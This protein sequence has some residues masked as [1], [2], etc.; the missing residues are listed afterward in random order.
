VALRGASA[1][2]LARSFQPAPCTL[3]VRLPDMSGWTVLEPPEAPIGHAS[4][5]VPR[6]SSGLEAISLTG[7]G[8]K[9]VDRLLPRLTWTGYDA[10]TRIGFQVV[11]NGPAAHVRSPH[12]QKSNRGRLEAPRKR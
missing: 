6:H 5:S 4:Y 7:G 8:I 9:R 3:D 1:I 11:E 10:W 12:I 2:T